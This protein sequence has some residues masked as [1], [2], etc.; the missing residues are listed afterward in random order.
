MD[1]IVLDIETKNTIADVGG[2]ENI[3]NLDISFVGAFSY[4]QNKYLSFFEKDF[5]SLEFLLKKTGLMIGFSSNRFDIPILSRH[6]N[7]NLKKIESLDMLDE[8]EEK[9]GHRIGLDQLAQAN[10]GI[11]KTGHGLEAITFYKE[12]RLEELEKYC[13]NDVK[14]TKELYELCKKQGHLLVPTDHGKRTIRV[15]FDWQDKIPL[16]NTLF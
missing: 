14:I 11:G 2:Q 9:L 10:L 12:G 8:V 16:A 7:M 13:I 15:K 6:F 4:S 5:K 1:K 3:K